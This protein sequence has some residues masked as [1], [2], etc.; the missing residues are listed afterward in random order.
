MV[1]ERAYCNIHEG[2]CVMIEDLRTDRVVMR[3]EMKDMRNSHKRDLEKRDAAMCAK[4]ITRTEFNLIK[5]DDYITKKE[6]EQVKRV[7]YLFIALVVAQIIK[8]YFL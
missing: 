4:Y 6:F 2:H 3:N 5:P 7:S 8:G 1:D